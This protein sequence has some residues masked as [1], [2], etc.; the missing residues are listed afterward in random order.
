DFFLMDHAFAAQSSL[1]APLA[2]GPTNVPEPFL[3][4]FAALGLLIL[5]RRGSIRGASGS[6][7][8]CSVGMTRKISSMP[9]LRAK[10]CR[11]ADEK[12]IAGLD[13]GGAFDQLG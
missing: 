13:G 11:L 5:R 3:P 1:P 9:N 6:S 8:R 2:F 12:Q 10:R 4:L 7:A